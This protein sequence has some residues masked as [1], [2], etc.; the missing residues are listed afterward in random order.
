M[1]IGLVR[2]FGPLV[3]LT[4]VCSGAV[5]AQQPIRIGASLSQTGAFAA[6][7]QNQLRGYQLCFK[8]AN[9]KGGVLGR[10]LELVFEDDQSQAPVA[11]RIYE[12]L[13]TQDK[14]DA[15]LG[16]YSSPITEAVA[17]VSE[18]HRMP[19][20]APNASTT[21]IFRKGRRFVFMV[22]SAAEVY[23]EG[24]IDIAAK[25]GLKT[26]AVIGEDT[27]FPKASTQGTVEQ[28]KSKGLQVVLAE[29]YPKG[30]TDFT[31]LLRKV[32]AANPDVV[33]AATYFDD[34]V[35]IT[36]ALKALDVNPKLFGVTVGGDV[37]KFHEVL[38]RDA[39]FVYG[40][41]QWLQELVT[42]RAGGLVPIARQYP[43]AAEFVE[44]HNKEFPGAGF[45]YQ[46]V[47]GYGGC[48]IF[49]EAVRRAQSLDG[50][51]IRNVIL[52]MDTYTAY[53]AFKVDEG[54]FQTAHKMVLFQWQ[55]GKKVVV[56]PEDLAADRPRFP[57][58]PWNK[59]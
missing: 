16:P 22:T 47:A 55:D 14:V 15:I 50:E 41:S 5:Q 46:T 48:Q 53:G 40:G 52:K 17:D 8:Q 13:I 24:L 23:L 26:V 37:P 33:A 7:G 11:V 57:T 51:R 10:K 20:V 36:R 29:S 18:K 27:L 59:R 44:A 35:A 2:A 49:L 45:S 3:L 19:M 34:A 30:T 32:R 1:R 6:L 43:G 42:L 39:E 4:A 38:G 28:A 31:A 56:W 25:R 54:G 9:E 21:S 12:K 58:P